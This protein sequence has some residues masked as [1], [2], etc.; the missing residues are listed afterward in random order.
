[1][2]AKTPIGTRFYRWVAAQPP[3]REYQP[4][5]ST[6]CACGCFMQDEFGIS[7]EDAARSFSNYFHEMGYGEPI[8]SHTDPSLVDF[9]REF[10]GIAVVGESTY[11][12]LRQ[13]LEARMPEVV[14]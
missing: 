6:D 12:A 13:R 5:L 10:N 1:M 14:A 8:Y 4:A 2:L 9:W 7:R 11:G 3:E